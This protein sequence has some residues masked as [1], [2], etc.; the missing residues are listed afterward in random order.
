VEFLVLARPGYELKVPP[1][2][3]IRYQFVDAPLFEL[4]STE[5]RTRLQRSE[6][7]ADWLPASVEAFIYEHKLYK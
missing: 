6:P 2:T 1:V 3:G 7:L 4:S 5:I